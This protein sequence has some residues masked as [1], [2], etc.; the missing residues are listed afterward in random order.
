MGGLV[1]PSG[2]D[3]MISAVGWCWSPVPPRQRDRP[4]W[5]VLCWL[6]GAWA[7]RHRGQGLCLP[8][9]GKLS[10]L[11]RLPF[12]L[13]SPVGGLGTLP[14]AAVLGPFCWSGRGL[15]TLPLA[16]V[17]GPFCWSGRRF[18]RDPWCHSC[19]SGASWFE[20][21]SFFSAVRIEKIELGSNFYHWN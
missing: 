8:L 11:Q 3:K 14:L 20:L 9:Q 16:A 2:P 13:G 18:A 17:L 1:C 4:S 15:G 12:K 21:N 7:G 10:V 5:A 6:E 19:Y